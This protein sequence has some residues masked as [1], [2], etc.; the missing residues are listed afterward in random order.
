MILDLLKDTLSFYSNVLDVEKF[1]S[2]QKEDIH[3]EPT[4]CTE[5]CS[6]TNQ[7][8]ISIALKIDIDL[9]T[10]IKVFNLKL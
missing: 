7:D 1:A 2:R 6:V 8:N 10:N 5:P 4:P 9:K 3:L